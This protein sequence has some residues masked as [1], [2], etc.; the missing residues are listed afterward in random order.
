MEFGD[1]GSAV[2][3]IRADFGID[4]E[5]NYRGIRPSEIGGLS[6]VHCAVGRIRYDLYDGSE[7]GILLYVKSSVTGEEPADI[8]AY[9][10]QHGEFPHEST[11]DQWFDEAQFESYRALGEHVIQTVLCDAEE[12]KQPTAERVFQ[13]A[14]KLWRAKPVTQP[15]GKRK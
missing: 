2:E 7:P 11:A 14:A 9:R 6:R 8:A 15:E 13:A 12:M 1:L 5:L 4:V 10:A 3:K